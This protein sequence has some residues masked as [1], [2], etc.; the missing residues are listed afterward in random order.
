MR[1]HETSI[2]AYSPIACGNRDVIVMRS[3]L[4]R[5]I[6]TKTASAFK[7]PPIKTKVMKQTNSTMRD[8]T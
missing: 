8:A 6:E 3:T 7:S 5:D 1:W 4:N 2:S